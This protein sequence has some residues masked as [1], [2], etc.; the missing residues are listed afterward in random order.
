MEWF[1]F[2][3]RLS[4]PASF[5]HTDNLNCYRDIKGG[6]TTGS[7]I[8]FNILVYNMICVY[9]S[10]TNEHIS[11]AFFKWWFAEWHWTVQQSSYGSI[12]TGDP[13][14]R[15]VVGQTSNLTSKCTSCFFL[16]INNVSNIL[17]TNDSQSNAVILQKVLPLGKLMFCFL[18]D[19]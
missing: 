14:G 6:S 4:S 5:L 9:T 18:T 2:I 19:W 7:K 1:G 17:K 12:N 8:S 3:C 16:F 15:L 13:G 11:S 10:I